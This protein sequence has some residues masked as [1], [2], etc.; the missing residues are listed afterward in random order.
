MNYVFSVGLLDLNCLKITFFSRQVYSPYELLVKLLYLIRG[1]SKYWIRKSAYIW[2]VPPSQVP[3]ESNGAMLFW[4]SECLFGHLSSFLELISWRKQRWI[5]V[6]T[7]A[8]QGARGCV[9]CLRSCHSTWHNSQWDKAFLLC[10]YSHTLPARQPWRFTHICWNTPGSFKPAPA[11]L[12]NRNI[13]VCVAPVLLARRM[14]VWFSS[15]LKCFFLIFEVLGCYTT[16]LVV[17]DFSGGP[18][19]PVFKGQAA[20]PLETGPMV[21]PETSLTDYQWSCVKL[22][23]N[24]KFIYPT[25]EA[26]FH[27]GCFS[28]LQNDETGS[29]QLG[30]TPLAHHR[31]IYLVV[32]LV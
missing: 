31:A 26:W 7:S 14:G 9:G 5:N 30:A 18:I 24:E 23:K 3:F 12:S 1:E 15:G 6:S 11:T 29:A 20:W 19:G 13:V 27:A 10:Y 4:G 21:C 28:H 16:R 17:T 32:L 2:N 22:R 25:S 8:E